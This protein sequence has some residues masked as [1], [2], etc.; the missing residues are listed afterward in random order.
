[1][2]RDRIVVREKGREYTVTGKE[3]GRALTYFTALSALR[4]LLGF[5]AVVVGGASMTAQILGSF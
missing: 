5:L 1:M 2:S 3:V 4:T